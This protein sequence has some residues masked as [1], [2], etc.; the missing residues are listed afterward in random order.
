MTN[1]KTI[2]YDASKCIPPLPQKKIF[3]PNNESTT[4][5]RNDGPDDVQPEQIA[6][7]QKLYANGTGISKQEI[8]QLVLGKLL[9][10]FGG[11]PAAMREC[12]SEMQ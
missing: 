11:R 8:T 4:D 9:G 7:M 1:N 12:W 6:F 5:R 10:L 2:L 3:Y